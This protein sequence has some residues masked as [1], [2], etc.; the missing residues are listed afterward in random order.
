M[1]KNVK[2]ESVGAGNVQFISAGKLEGPG[3]VLEGTFIEALPNAFDQNKRD[4]KFETEEGKIVVL[5]GTGQLAHRMKLV[6]EGDLVQI[7]YL[8]KQKIS[9][10]VMKGKEAHNFD[11]RV[12]RLDG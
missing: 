8:G 7:E 5:N 12:A 1:T 11:V 6:K 4:Y 10:G 9:K 3:L 2:F